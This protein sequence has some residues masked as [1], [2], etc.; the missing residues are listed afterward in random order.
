L[1]KLAAIT[2]IVSV[3]SI[4][5]VFGQEA[6]FVSKVWVS[7]NGDSTCKNPIIHTDYSDPDMVRVGFF[8][9]RPGR[10]NDAG[11]A[12]IDWIRFEK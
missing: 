3:L 11:S 1:R 9:T 5:S 6:P 2:L 7:D 4:L 12:D 8:F 10:F